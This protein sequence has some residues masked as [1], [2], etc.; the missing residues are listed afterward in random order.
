[1]CYLMKRHDIVGLSKSVL[2]QICR[3]FQTVFA[4]SVRW[5][6]TF[7][8][9]SFFVLSRFFYKNDIDCQSREGMEVQKYR[10]V[11]VSCTCSR[12]NVSEHQNFVIDIR[13]LNFSFILLN[14][15]SFYGF[16]RF[17]QYLR[18]P[19]FG[20]RFHGSIDNFDKISKVFKLQIGLFEA[21]SC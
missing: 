7:F 4:E 13:I 6:Y 18:M 21:L 19:H 12:V 17:V 11:C 20:H 3:Q 15:S 1:M 10:K 9:L 2:K 14:S 8:H 16:G 5:I